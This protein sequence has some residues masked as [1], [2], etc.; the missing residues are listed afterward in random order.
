MKGKVGNIVLRFINLLHDLI[1]ILNLN[2]ILPHSIAKIPSVNSATHITYNFHK[3]V[4]NS[5]LL[6]NGFSFFT[7]SSSNLINSYFSAQPFSFLISKP[8]F[9]NTPNKITIQFFYYIKNKHD[10]FENLPN[11]L[12]KSNKEV[13]GPSF[14]TLRLRRN[15]VNHPEIDFSHKSG[16]KFSHSIFFPSSKTNNYTSNE[17]SLLY[18]LNN[19]NTFLSEL[20]QKEVELIINRVHYP[21]MNSYILAQYLCHNAPSNTFLNFQEAILSYPSVNASIL[22]SYINGV[23]IGLSGRLVTEPVIPRMTTKTSVRA[24]RSFTNNK[25]EQG[26]CHMDYAKFTYK[27]ELGAFTIKVWIGSTCK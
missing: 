25:S 15:V 12:F 27:N 1:L 17:N 3:K 4:V 2:I 22:P 19:L 21:Y 5:F 18:S 9:I 8:K 14:S 7:S 6:K 23:K 13:T 16:F 11:E 24:A 20:Y 26:K 10:P